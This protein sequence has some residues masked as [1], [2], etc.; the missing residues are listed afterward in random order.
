M[1]ESTG[2]AQQAGQAGE[3][4]RS[5]SRRF[6]RPRQEI[7]I[8]LVMLG[9]FVFLRLQL[10]DLVRGRRGAA[11]LDPDFW[12]G[13]LLNLLIVLVVI[14]LVQAIMRVV[15][16]PAV[17]PEAKP[18]AT[19]GTEPAGMAGELAADADASADAAPLEPGA[20]GPKE[21]EEPEADTAQPKNPAMLLAGFGLIFAFI[22]LMPRIGFIPSGLLFAVAFL[23]AV[24]ER[25]VRIVATIPV[26]L[27]ALILYVFT[28]LL[29]VP[30]PRGQGVFLQFST[31]FY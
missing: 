9:L 6:D 31:Y 18:P 29:V 19:A 7:L 28:R 27:M 13:W 12:P 1:S 2:K 5:L 14:Y 15:R 23:L 22:W 25:R 26:V 16:A 4:D 24:G 3:K 30:L 20:E 21:P 8:G 11:F 10:T 17:E